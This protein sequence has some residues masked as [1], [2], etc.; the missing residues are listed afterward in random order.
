MASFFYY[1][2]II[3]II[4]FDNE[5]TQN[6]VSVMSFAN[7]VVEDTPRYAGRLWLLNVLFLLLSVYRFVVQKALQVIQAEVLASLL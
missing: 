6:K 3:K 4:F 2:R 5:D 1:L 7:K